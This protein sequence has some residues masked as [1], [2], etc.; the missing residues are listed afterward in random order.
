MPVEQCTVT[1]TPC[2]ERETPATKLSTYAES[3]C[4]KV[5]LSL[6]RPLQTWKHVLPRQTARSCIRATWKPE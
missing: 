4:G 2:I 1:V 3:V 6:D 5:L